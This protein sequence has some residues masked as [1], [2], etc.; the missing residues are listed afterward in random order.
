MP[1]IIIPKKCV[2]EL[3]K[4]LDEV[5]GTAEVSLSPTKVRFG[6]GS[7]VLTSKLIDGTFPDYNRVIPT[8]NDK[9]SNSIRR[10]SP[11]GSIASPPS[12]R[13]T[14]RGQDERRPRQGHAA[15]SPAE[16]GAATRK[17]PLTPARTISR[18]GS[19]PAT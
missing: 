19:T 13:K 12:P 5:E 16:S 18:S 8:G 3:R 1:D 14:A 17:S 10:A 4:L 11:P 15:R 7:A 2:G 6:L 9:C